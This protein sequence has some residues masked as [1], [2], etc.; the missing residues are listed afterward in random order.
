MIENRPERGT[1]VP[2]PTTDTAAAVVSKPL[3]PREL[4]ARA[5]ATLDQARTA[6]ASPLTENAGRALVLVADGYRNLAAVV[7]ANVHLQPE[8]EGNR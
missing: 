4:A 6:A 5:A 7:A 8:Q 3:T 2:D 1:A